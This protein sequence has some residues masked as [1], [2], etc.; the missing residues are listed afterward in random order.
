MADIENAWNFVTQANMK[1]QMQNLMRLK[2]KVR[3]AFGTLGI[4]SANYLI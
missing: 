1:Y 2:P 3:K 4:F